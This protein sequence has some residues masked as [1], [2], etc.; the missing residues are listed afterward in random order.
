M[1]CIQFHKGV[2]TDRNNV[3]IKSNKGSPHVKVYTIFKLV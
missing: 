2:M 3:R 1:C